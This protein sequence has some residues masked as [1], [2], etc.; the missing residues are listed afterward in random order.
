[1][2]TRLFDY[3]LPEAAIAQTPIEPRDGARLLRTHPRE[4]RQFSEFPSLLREGDLVVV[5]RTRVRAA[6][7]RAR[8]RDTGGAVEILLL[9]RLDTERWEALVKPARRIRAGLSLDCGPI[10]AEVLTDPIQ[11]QVV[12]AVEAPGGDVE[13]AIAAVG[14]VPLPPYIHNPI[15]DPGRYQTLFAKTVGSAAAPTAALH[16]TPA[17][18]QGIEAAG[19]AITEVELEIG[20]DTFRPIATGTI[21]EHEM[22]CEAWV[23]PQATEEAVAETRRR[24]GRVIAVGTT[25]AR[26]LES[27]AAGKGY[28]RAGGGD[29][30]LFISPGYELRVIDVILTNFHAPRTS[31]IVMVAALLGDDW[32]DLYRHAIESGYRFLS[33]GDAMLIEDPVNRR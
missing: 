14:E 9:R 27:A 2:E 11:G 28:V 31:L 29:T 32:R 10:A 20:L 7:L 18:V 23:L 15:G 4:D 12:V 17:V 19:V 8:K 13:Q 25:V 24:G 3:D 6:R 22:H 26:T 33:F 21:D 16:F 5:N 1:V 30:D